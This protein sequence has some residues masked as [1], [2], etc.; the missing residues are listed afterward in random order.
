MG[1][2][3]HPAHAEADLTAV[4]RS[5]VDIVKLATAMLRVNADQE[6]FCRL[7]AEV[8]RRWPNIPQEHQDYAVG[9]ATGFLAGQDSILERL[10][11]PTRDKLRTESHGN[12]QN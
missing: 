12:R 5:V 10:D 7:H 11:E 8:T 3:Q 9:Y 4:T 1:D 2:Q 6:G